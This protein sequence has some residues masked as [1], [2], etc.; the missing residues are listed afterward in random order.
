MRDSMVLV[1]AETVRLL[2]KFTVRVGF[3]SVRC[4]TFW[5]EMERFLVPVQSGMVPVLASP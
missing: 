1:R 2:V 5:L 4:G 3:V